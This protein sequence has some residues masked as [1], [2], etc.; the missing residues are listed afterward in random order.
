M[1]LCRKTQTHP[2]F[3]VDLLQI[4]RNYILLIELTA[5]IGVYIYHI[6]RLRGLAF[7]PE[8]LEKSTFKRELQPG[9]ALLRNVIHV[10]DAYIYN[11]TQWFR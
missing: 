8:F 9:K 2:L 4:I 1:L 11:T 6:S 3:P 10:K 5:Y 7:L